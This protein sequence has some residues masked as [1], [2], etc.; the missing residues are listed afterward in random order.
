V[1]HLVLQVAQAEEVA[2]EH[3]LGAVFLNI[4]FE[5]SEASF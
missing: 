3:N 2:F 1:Q 5:P 4:F